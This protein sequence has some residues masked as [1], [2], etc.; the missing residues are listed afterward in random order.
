MSLADLTDPNAIEKATEEADALG[1]QGF[2]AKYGFSPSREYFLRHNGI[3]YDS[4]AI[5]AAAHGYQHPDLGPLKATEFSGGAQTVQRKLEQLGYAVEIPLELIDPEATSRLMT[6]LYPDSDN[7]NRAAI[8][9]ARSIELAES[10]RPGVWSVTAFP[11]RVRLNVGRIAVLDLTKGEIT[12]VIP[13]QAMTP[14]LRGQLEPWTTSRDWGTKTVALTGVQVPID[15][16][17]EAMGLLLDDHENAIKACARTA[18][19]AYLKSHSPGVTEWLRTEAGLSAP[20]PQPSATAFTATHTT[21]SEGLNAVLQGYPAA[22]RGTFTGSHSINGVF[23]GLVQSL[24]SSNSVKAFPT[25]RVRFSTG[26]G[27]WAR[28]PWIALLDERNTTTTQ[29]GVYC[30]YLF[31][32]D[33]SGVYLCLAQGVTEPQR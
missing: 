12:V 15:R 31:R 7:L 10:L 27:N 29:S 32:E 6:S 26:Q 19:V 4:K 28:V 24:E 8:R 33:G 21:L 3:L 17:D 25:L 9:L 14:S 5:V 22:R 16:L 23:H 18:T 11:D 2:L 13:A 1:P 20:D 30:V